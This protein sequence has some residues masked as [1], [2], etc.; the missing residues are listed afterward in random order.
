MPSINYRK[1]LTMLGLSLLTGG[2]LMSNLAVA[3]V[4][5]CKQANGLFSFQASPCSGAEQGEKITVRPTNQSES[6]PSRL[7]SSDPSQQND[8]EQRINDSIKKYNRES[9]KIWDNYY[10]EKCDRYTRYHEKAVADWKVKMHRGYKEYEKNS[11]LD[12]IASTKSDM[13]RECAEKR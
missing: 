10:T 1:T 12:E 2:L 11:M 7:Y 4:Y 9:K 13:S 3:D 6:P 5:K 8:A